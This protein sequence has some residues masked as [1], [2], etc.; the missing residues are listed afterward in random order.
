[1]IGVPSVRHGYQTNTTTKCVRSTLTCKIASVSAG[2]DF[3]H[4]CPP[5]ITIYRQQKL[6]K[7]IKSV[8]K[9][10]K[11]RTT[12]ASKPPGVVCLCHRLQGQWPGIDL[13]GPPCAWVHVRAC[14]DGQTNWLVIYWHQYEGSVWLMVPF[15]TRKWEKAGNSEDDSICISH[16]VN[17]R[18]SPLQVPGDRCVG[19]CHCF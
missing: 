13:L 3:T 8:L 2:G 18:P 17:K 14:M 12:G 5:L 7:C 1:M 16:V 19:I 4:H 15:R 11:T 10:C 9:T 6:N